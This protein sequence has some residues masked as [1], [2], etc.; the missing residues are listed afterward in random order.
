[1]IISDEWSMKVF[2]RE[3]IDLYEAFSLGRAAPLPEPSIQYADFARWEVHLVE[4]GLLHKQ[5]VYWRK[6]LAG[7]LPELQFRKARKGK[8]TLSFRTMRHT[9][10]VDKNLSIAIKMLASKEHVTPFIVVLSA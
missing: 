6:Q 9:I 4:S 1:H 2:R 10:D 3:L 7:P 5:V 8:R